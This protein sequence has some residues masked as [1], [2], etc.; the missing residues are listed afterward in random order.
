MKN[1]SLAKPCLGDPTHRQRGQLVKEIIQLLIDEPKITLSQMAC[2]L[3]C[4]HENI[5]RRYKAIVDNS[6][7]YAAMAGIDVK[8]LKRILCCREWDQGTGKCGLQKRSSWPAWKAAGHIVGGT[9]IYA[10]R[11]PLDEV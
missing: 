11:H 6:N 7:K 10:Y 4:G 3:D 9:A 2:R 8:I 1:K 5:R